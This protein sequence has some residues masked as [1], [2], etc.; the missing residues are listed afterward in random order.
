GD[1]S[2]FKNAITATR[3]KFDAA[4]TATTSFKTANVPVTGVGFFD[5][6]HGQTGVAPNG[7]ELHPL[8][9]IAFT[10]A[11]AA[12]NLAGTPTSSAY[13]PNITKTLGGP[14]GF[15]TPFI[16]Q[17]VGTTTTGLQVSFYRFSDGSLVTC[18][19][20]TG[21]G[22]G[23]SFADIPNNDGDLPGIAQFSVVVRSYGGQV[24]A[25]VNEH[26]ASGARAEALSYDG[27]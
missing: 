15:Y 5:F 21:V 20:I 17:N 8:L 26:A 18:R 13:L 7:I 25:V 1:T 22:P 27:F 9:D 2:P 16:V 10:P 12:C 11:P 23:T 6:L 4:Y 24:V 19:K 14:S 3:A